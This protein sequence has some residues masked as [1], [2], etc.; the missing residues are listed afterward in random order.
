MPKHHAS[1]TVLAGSLPSE[2]DGASSGLTAL[3]FAPTTGQLTQHHHIPAPRFRATSFLAAHPSLDV[4]YAT[5]PVDPGTIS[6]VTQQREGALRPLGG[7]VRSG[8]VNPCH[9]SVHP[10][11]RW[12]LTAHYGNGTVPG[13]VAVHRLDEAGFVRALADVA[14]HEGRGPVAERQEN[15]HAHQIVVDPPG[16]FVLATDLGSDSVFAYRLDS[17]TGHLQQAAVSKLLPGTGPRHLVFSPHEELVFTV[18]ELSST[19]TSHR[20]DGRTGTLTPRSAVPSSTR[21]VP[22]QPGAIAVSPCGRY[23]WVSNRGADTV[24]AFRVVGHALRPISEVSCGG[25]WPRA[26]TL[27]GNHLIV[28]NQL[29]GTVAALR[30]RSSG[31]LEEPRSSASVAS[32]VCSLVI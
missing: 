1:L 16:R 26:L 28:T 3:Q 6:A 20:Y 25:S 15:S 2:A 13:S 4:V 23:V 27:A 21:A 11:G 14:W 24:A 7:P 31:A 19:V 17:R 5:H 9:L 30:V 8:G 22:N 32:A 29:S 10:N 18:D 12:L